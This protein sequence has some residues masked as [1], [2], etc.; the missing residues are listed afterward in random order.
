M[1]GEA[2]FVRSFADLESHLSSNDNI[3][4]MSLQQFADDFL[5]AFVGVQV[6]GVKKIHSEVDSPF[7]CWFCFLRL[8]HPFFGVTERHRAETDPRDLESCRPKSGVLHRSLGSMPP[9]QCAFKR[10][11]ASPV[12]PA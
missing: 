7:Y 6:C 11:T 4:P 5:G 10:S 8:D 3:I 12:S 1:S 2:L 9:F